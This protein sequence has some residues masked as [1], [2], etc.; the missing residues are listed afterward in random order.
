MT[1]DPRPRRSL[2]Y[3]PASNARAIDKARTLPADCIILDLEDS[4]PPEAKAD[5]RVQM[6]AVLREGA[7]GDRE[8][9]VRVNGLDTPWGSDD[10]AALIP[11]Y[12][13]IAAVVAPKV[14]GSEGVSRYTAR[15]MAAP[16][17]VSIWAMVESCRAVIT[18]D[19][20]AGARR[21]SGLILG[22]N[23]LGVEMGARPGPDREPFQPVMTLAICAAK[24]HGKLVF[25]GVCNAIDDQLAFEREVRQAR[26][27]G[28]DGKTLI[29]PKQIDPC[30]RAFS[31]T[32]EEAAWARAVVAGFDAGG[33][34]GGAIRVDGK[35]VEKMHLDLARKILA[36]PP[37]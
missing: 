36:A 8:V 37:S 17:R 12:G 3:V 34:D 23:D 31:P 25:D 19:A 18:V 28:F 20:I 35:M 2:L 29:H 27:F 9:L 15:L 21:V 4:V 26:A 13:H 7:L 24:A 5:A 6:A 14:M 32:P 11:L 33:S 1:P 16:E 10:F 22:L 30:N